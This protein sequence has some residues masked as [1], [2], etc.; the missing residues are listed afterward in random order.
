M[1]GKKITGKYY[2]LQNKAKYIFIATILILM[3]ETDIQN[4]NNYVIRKIIQSD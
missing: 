2:L 3:D 1:N 4:L